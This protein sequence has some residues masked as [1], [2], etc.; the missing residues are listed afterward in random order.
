MPYS[1][2]NSHKYHMA[3]LDSL[4]FSQSQIEKDK[5]DAFNFTKN[6]FTE[7]EG[8]HIVRVGDPIYFVHKALMT[9]GISRWYKLYR[10]VAWPGL[11]IILSNEKR[12][13]EDEMAWVIGRPAEHYSKKFG[14]GTTFCDDF[15]LLRIRHA[16]PLEI[17]K[18]RLL[19]NN[20]KEAN[21]ILF[22]NG[23]YL[24]KL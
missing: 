7:A 17:I 9:P 19:L 1:W 11:P 15:L 22:E 13:K 23:N 20:P 24:N 5:T 2:E 10:N 16:T 6:C 14:F 18:H 4:D 3:F 8:F 12:N 21:D